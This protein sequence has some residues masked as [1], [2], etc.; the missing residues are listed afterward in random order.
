MEAMRA[1]RAMRVLAAAGA[2]GGHIFPAIGFLDDIKAAHPD[3]NT[4]LVLPVRSIKKNIDLGGHSVRNIG[5]SSLSLKVNV[6]NI[7]AAFDFIKGFFESAGILSQFKPD[8]V[9][10]FG[11]IASIPLVSCAWFFRTPVMIHEQ[12]V[13]PGRANRFLAH[14]SDRIAVSFPETADVLSAGR[15]K[16]VW[17]GN[18]LR[19]SLSVIDKNKA[20]EYF[21]LRTGRKTLLVMGGSQA[22]RRINFGFASAF[23]NLHGRDGV[24]VIHLCGEADKAGLEKEYAA[25]SSNVR[26]LPF[27][28]E[29]QYAY[30]A[31]D[32]VVSR[33]GATTI[34][35]LMAYRI[36]AILVPYPY[37]YAHQDAN[38]R[39]LV[40]AGCAH[41]VPDARIFDGL[42]H[43]TLMK[44]IQGNSLGAMAAGYDRFAGMKPASLADEALKI[45]RHG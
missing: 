20:L 42:L 22:S 9:V 5:V 18:A 27:L 43:E 45:S 11:S 7:R 31:A 37:A 36:P 21:G 19:R 12:N 2:S 28:N 1:M 35:E 30:S 13:I 8:I 3:A 44:S 25:C 16:L 34:A 24:Q 4:M 17:T 10:G 6:A 38:A 39:V 23:K 29:M 26:L 33:A 40:R 32:L 14:I 15:S 41:E